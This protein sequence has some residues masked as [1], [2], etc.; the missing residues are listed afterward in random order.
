MCIYF[1]NVVARFRR[2]L[3]VG[4]D[5]LGGLV[6]RLLAPH[7]STRLQ[8]GLVANEYERHVLGILHAQYL[9]AELVEHVERLVLGNGED[10]QKALATAEVV[11]AYGRVVLLAGRVQYVD[12]HFFAVQLHLLAVRVR[13]G[14]LVVLDELVVHVLEREGRL[15]HAA[16]AHHDHL[17]DGRLFLAI[18]CR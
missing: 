11:V 17:V 7:L 3:D 13:F 14:R 5:P 8:V 18:L 9:L 10:E 6:A 2:R 15:A 4:L 1:V 16:A 12:L